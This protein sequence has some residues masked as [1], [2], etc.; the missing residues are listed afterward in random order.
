MAFAAAQNTCMHG[1][2]DRARP[3]PDIR[4]ARVGAWHLKAPGRADPGNLTERNASMKSTLAVGLCLVGSLYFAAPSSG[5]ASTLDEYPLVT[6]LAGAYE[7]TKDAAPIFVCR[8]QTDPTSCQQ[9]RFGLNSNGWFFRF[10][11]ADGQ[12]IYCVRPSFWADYRVCAK[13]LISWGEIYNGEHWVYA[14]EGDA[15]CSKWGND[16]SAEYLACEAALPP[17]NS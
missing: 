1:D 12:R 14:R 16:L 13:M 15:R 11:L 8:N 6:A 9:R 7:A 4:D 5:Y 3:R 2:Q 10:D 17:S